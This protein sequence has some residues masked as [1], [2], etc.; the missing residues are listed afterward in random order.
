VD[1]RLPSLLDEKG[2]Y[3]PVAFFNRLDE[4]NQR[5]TEVFIELANRYE[6]DF[7]FVVYSRHL[8]RQKHLFFLS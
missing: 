5:R 1:E 2:L 8:L 3:E 6:I 7:G 4:M